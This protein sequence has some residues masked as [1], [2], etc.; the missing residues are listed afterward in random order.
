MKGQ[1]PATHAPLSLREQVGQARAIA[2]VAHAG[3]VDKAGVDYIRHPEMVAT[4]SLV[5]ATASPHDFT[6]DEL[7]R[8]EAAALLHDV[9][10]D[11]PFEGADLL[12]LGIDDQTVST[13]MALTHLANEPRRLYYAR[14]LRDPM[15]VI[16]KQADVEH[17]SAPHRLAGLDPVTRKRLA[18]KYVEARQALGMEVPGYL[19]AWVEGRTA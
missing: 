15:A 16:V 14:I 7:H 8:I 19:S 3:Q 13:V 1:R 10:E 17:N 9:V 4:L 18:S 6:V 11:T 12:S 2:T 5:L